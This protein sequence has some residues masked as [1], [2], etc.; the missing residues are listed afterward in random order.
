ME[1]YSD[2]PSFDEFGKNCVGSVEW[3]NSSGFELESAQLQGALLLGGKLI[4]EKAKE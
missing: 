1:Y 3:P 4:E 2:L